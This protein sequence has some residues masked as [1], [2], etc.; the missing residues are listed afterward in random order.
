MRAS[1]LLKQIMANITVCSDR[2]LTHTVVVTVNLTFSRTTGAAL[3]TRY[4][5]KKPRVGWV[6]GRTAKVLFSI[7]YGPVLVVWSSRAVRCVRVKVL[8]TIVARYW[9]DADD[10]W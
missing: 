2:R 4:S 7:T 1:S 6:L 8:L 10:G 9:L 5:I 3:K